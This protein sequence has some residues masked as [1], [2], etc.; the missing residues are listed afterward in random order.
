MRGC[1]LPDFSRRR[2]VAF[3]TGSLG[4]LESVPCELARTA[5]HALVDLNA[6][7]RRNTEAEMYAS[8]QTRVIRRAQKGVGFGSLA[9]ALLRVFD[10]IAG[11]AGLT[12][13]FWVA[14][15]RNGAGNGAEHEAGRGTQKM[16]SLSDGRC[17]AGWREAGKSASGFRPD[18]A[19]S[20]PA[21]LL[22]RADPS[23]PDCRA[24]AG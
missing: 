19:F 22:R 14:M 16:P 24:C 13:L 10:R 23:H 9:P 5:G 17:V 15:P 2:G 21:I 3:A 8:R 1:R 6:E 18:F 7:L 20:K 4:V 12:G 11:F